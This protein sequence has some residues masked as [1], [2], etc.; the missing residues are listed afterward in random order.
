MSAAIQQASTPR[1]RLL[2]S[3]LDQLAPVY[4]QMYDG[5]ME[6]A[7][8]AASDAL[9]PYVQDERAD[10]FVAGQI[11]ACGLISMRIFQNCM[12]EDVTEAELARLTRTA[13]TLSRTTQRHRTSGLYPP[14]EARPAPSRTPKPHAVLPPPAQ[15]TAAEPSTQPIAQAPKPAKADAVKVS[16]PDCALRS[17]ILA[18]SALSGSLDPQQATGDYI[19]S[20][21]GIPNSPK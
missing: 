14:A 12:R 19:F 16:K 6:T 8:Q 9:D 10:L 7:R 3:V 5:D 4:A 18:S 1:E 17:R 11:I 20:T 21:T 2:V 13:D 15:A